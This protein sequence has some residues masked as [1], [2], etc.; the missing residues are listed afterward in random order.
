MRYAE[1]KDQSAE[2]LRLALPLMARRFA[3]LH[4]VSYTDGSELAGSVTLSLGVA[5]GRPADT[6]ESLITRADAALYEAKRTGRNLVC[7]DASAP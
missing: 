7:V 6:L 1:N 5:V 4:P 3:A 2:L